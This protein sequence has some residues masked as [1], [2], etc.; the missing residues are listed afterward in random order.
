VEAQIDSVRLRLKMDSEEDA[1]PDVPV[2]LV[3]AMIHAHL[4][5]NDSAARKTRGDPKRTGGATGF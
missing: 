1:A 3:E 4:E 2:E 5:E